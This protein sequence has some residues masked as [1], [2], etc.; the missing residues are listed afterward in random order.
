MENISLNKTA[1]VV[2]LGN[3][4][5]VCAMQLYTDFF[6]PFLAVLYTVHSIHKYTK[7]SPIKELSEPLNWVQHPPTK[8][9][10]ELLNWVQHQVHIYWITKG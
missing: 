10:S 1:Q 4:C 5:K 3:K 6:T 7:Y 9:L 8:E 2:S